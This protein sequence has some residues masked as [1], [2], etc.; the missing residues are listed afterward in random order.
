MPINVPTVIKFREDQ[1]QTFYHDVMVSIQGVDVSAYLTGTMTITLTDRMGF[2]NCS[3]TLDNAYDRFVITQKNAEGIQQVSASGL[4]L[5]K[6]F[7]IDWGDENNSSPYSE[8]SKFRIVWTKLGY[9]GIVLGDIDQYFKDLL[10]KTND[11][12]ANTDKKISEKMQSE[13]SKAKT[14]S[15]K[16]KASK[17]I[18]KYMNKL[19]KNGEEVSK[20]KVFL[21]SISDR[22]LNDKQYEDD[23]AGFI[24]KNIEED[25]INKLFPGMPNSSSSMALELA[26]AAI[27]REKEARNNKESRNTSDVNPKSKINPIDPLTGEPR[28]PFP[29]Q[30]LVFHK[31]DPVRIFYH[32][33][34]SEEDEWVPAFCGYISTY[35]KQMDYTTGTSNIQVECYDIRYIMQKMR[36]Q[37][38]PYMNTPDTP[39]ENLFNDPDNFF[40]DLDVRRPAGM[41]HPFAN[42][43]LEDAFEALL[44]GQEKITGIGKL[45]KGARVLYPGNNDKESQAIL[46]KWHHLSV[47]GTGPQ[48]EQALK[49]FDD[50]DITFYTEKQAAAVC[51]E[52]KVG[53]RFSPDRHYVHFLL[54]KE[55][56]CASNLVHYSY[57]TGNMQRSWTTRFDMLNELA[58]AIDYQWFVSPFGD[59]MIEF[60]LYDFLPKDLGNIENLFEAENHLI[61]SSNSPETGDIVTGLLVTGNWANATKG[62]KSQRKPPAEWPHAHIQSQVLAAR[63]GVTLETVDFPYIPDNDALKNIGLMEFQKRLARANE[64]SVNFGYRPFLVINRPFLVKP[65][66]R[67]GLLKTVTMSWTINEACNTNVTLEYIRTIRS[68]GTYRLITGAEAMPISY[69]HTFGGGSCGNQK[70]ERGVRVYPTDTQEK[71]PSHGQLAKLV[72]KKSKEIGLDSALPKAVIESESDWRSDATGYKKDGGIG[73]VGVMQVNPDSHKKY[74]MDE[75][76]DPDKNIELGTKQYK[77]ELDYWKERG[78]SDDDAEEWAAVSY[79]YGHGGADRMYDEYGGDTS[80]IPNSK[81]QNYLS[82]FRNNRDKYRSA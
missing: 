45:K 37:L 40:S 34:L 23:L 50:L 63:I 8:F 41:S 49:N 51:S 53:G 16:D 66:K 39:A 24:A 14:D 69:K 79:N 42:W 17:N 33:P 6:Y 62:D 82:K 26:K 20:D 71:P 19:E 74:T 54:P 28:Y 60:P 75:L 31:M 10:K 68:D 59:I 13:L 80:K 57:I 9:S 30:G 78:L 65:D 76:Y 47:F 3:F 58:G 77:K 48:Y 61:D 46:N 1:Y 25:S 43:G 72:D 44:C 21:S 52:T 4:E 55:G 38:D 35:P 22:I 7:R 12:Y 27:R 36:I 29:E 32:N 67:V 73:G 70:G 81:T 64:F 11:A 56:T 5:A 18:E 15:Q 2:N